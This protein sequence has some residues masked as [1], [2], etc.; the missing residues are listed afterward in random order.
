MRPQ[1]ALTW[2]KRQ[3]GGGQRRSSVIRVIPCWGTG[4]EP[5]VSRVSGHVRTL[6]QCELHTVSLDYVAHG[7]P[8]GLHG[9]VKRG[10]GGAS[11]TDVALLLQPFEAELRP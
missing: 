4:A 10:G 6:E 9:H 11:G 8:A 1:Q 5:P 3:A 2:G 7:V